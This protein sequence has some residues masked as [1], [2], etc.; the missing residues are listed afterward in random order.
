M[1]GS[2][3]GTDDGTVCVYYADLRY[4]RPETPETILSPDERDRAGRYR[5][6]ADSLRYVRARCLLREVLAFYKNCTPQEIRFGHGKHG[7]PFLEGEL[8]RGVQFNASHSGDMVAVA[9]SRGRT[10]GI[11]IEAIRDNIPEPDPVL[12]FFSTAETA[13]IQ[14][15]RGRAKAEL[16]LRTWTRKEALLKATGEGIGGIAGIPDLPDSGI[17]TLNG[18][19]WQL[20]D[21]VIPE[22][23]TGALAAEG[24]GSVVR[25]TRF[26]A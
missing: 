9:V 19:V 17:V 13:A 14:N 26:W 1:N 10:V 20:H 16:F 22:G 12:R 3:T 8:S 23:Y 15:L 18:T 25:T 5:F 4:Y 7:K 11:D 21:L 2:R 24:T 6:A